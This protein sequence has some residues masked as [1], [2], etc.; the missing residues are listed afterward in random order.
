M[1]ER[2]LLAEHVGLDE[3]I[4]HR[5]AAFFVIGKVDT[6]VS[7]AFRRLGLEEE[8]WCS[9]DEFQGGASATGET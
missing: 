1:R 7:H 4:S 8:Q 5:F 3:S 2:R 6:W 9:W